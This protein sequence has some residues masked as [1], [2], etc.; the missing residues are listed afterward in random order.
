MVPD[1]YDT[2]P[3]ENDW[4]RPSTS[5]GGWSKMGGRAAGDPALERR[6]DLRCAA[7]GNLRSEPIFTPWNKLEAWQVTDLPRTPLVSLTRI[8]IP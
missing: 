3:V 2:K 4:M 6:T 8:P 7:N 1:P 5:A